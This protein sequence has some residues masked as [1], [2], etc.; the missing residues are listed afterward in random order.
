MPDAD[1]ETETTTEWWDYIE[2]LLRERDVAPTTWAREVGLAATLPGIWKRDGGVPRL[3]VMRLVADYFQRP[4]RE[5]LIKAGYATAEELGYSLS[6]PDPRELSNDILLHEL[7]RRL[8][9]G[10]SAHMDAAPEVSEL[11]AR[12]PTRR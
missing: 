6:V 5:V 1:T 10:E 9:A 2:G 4:M 3:S 8:R 7:G 11:T 12:R